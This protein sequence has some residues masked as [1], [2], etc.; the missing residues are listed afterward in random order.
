MSKPVTFEC[1]RNQ[2]PGVTKM[3]YSCLYDE[4]TGT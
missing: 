2:Y 4:G 3:V 1:L